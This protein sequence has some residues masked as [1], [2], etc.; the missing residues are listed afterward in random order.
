V[1]G[2][3]LCPP[4]KKKWLGLFWIDGVADST[5][6]LVDDINEWIEWPEL[7]FR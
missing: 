2:K 1:Q 4:P 5:I 7:L 6:A 3:E